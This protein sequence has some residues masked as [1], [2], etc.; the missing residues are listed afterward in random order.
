MEANTKLA[1]YLWLLGAFALATDTAEFMRYRC[2]PPKGKLGLF[3]LALT[4]PVT[5]P[6]VAASEVIEPRASESKCVAKPV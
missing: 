2:E 6:I 3:A 5:V 1:I 4:W